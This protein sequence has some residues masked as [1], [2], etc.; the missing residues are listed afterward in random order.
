MNNFPDLTL[1]GYRITKKL[2]QNFQGGRVTYLATEID[3]DRPV[4]L[5]Q[6]RFGQ[7]AENWHGYNSIEAEIQVLQRLN[8]PQIPGYISS[9][10]TD[11]GFYLV[12]EYIDAPTLAQT[13]SLSFQEIKAIAIQLLD[14]LQN[15]QQLQ[16]PIIHRDIKP[17]NILLRRQGQAWQVFLIDF[18]FARL[19]EGDLS[20]SSTVKG[21]LGFMPPEQIFQRELTTASDLYS[22]G[23]TLISVLCG[24]PS[25]A[26]AALIGSDYR[27]QFRPHLNDDLPTYFLNWLD[28]IT[29]P[30]L[31]QRY[32]DANT[33][34][35]ALLNLEKQA[36]KPLSPIPKKHQLATPAKLIIFG[37]VSTIFGLIFFNSLRMSAP[38]LPISNNPS[39]VEPDPSPV[40][41]SITP[42]VSEGATN[43]K[44]AIDEL[45]FKAE[46][47]YSRQRYDEA[48]YY[49][50]LV[51]ELDPNHF[52]ALSGKCA[53][54][55]YLKLYDEALAACEKAIAIN[56]QDY[57]VY[58]R[59]GLVLT[60]GLGRHTEAVIS[61]ERSQTLKP[62]YFW[63]WVNQARAL[64]SLGQYNEAIAAANQGIELRPDKSGGYVEKCKAYRGLG[65]LDVA[66]ELCDQRSPSTQNQNY[67]TIFGV[68][69]YLTKGNMSKP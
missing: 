9:F 62:S 10:M 44:R 34:L 31:N 27:I 12:M 7:G 35:Q 64:T 57:R 15:L 53:S 6:F 58:N 38:E 60:G 40:P 21:T 55:Y 51:L 37:I 26:I 8:H 52:E 23:I 65:E 29:E 2:G 61:F 50:E 24:K 1:H 63:P 36:L 13:R 47:A 11:S 54:C 59:H 33:A 19:F 28:T 17:E 42:S 43:M 67:P 32:P 68:E 4:V 30:D 14:I 46:E 49:Y 56:D 25:E 18:G 45:F 3:G 41:I 16:P 66:L 20:A 5:K 69:F 39:P 22:L 48:S